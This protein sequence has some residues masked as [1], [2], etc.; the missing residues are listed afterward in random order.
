MLIRM[1]RTFCSSV[2]VAFAV[3]SAAV[4]GVS[5][6]AAVAAPP[7]ATAPAPA[8]AALVPAPAAAA[9]LPGL[10]SLPAGAAV[11]AGTALPAGPADGRNEVKR[12]KAALLTAGDLPAGYQR[13]GKPTIFK[14]NLLAVK[15][16]KPA[17]CDIALGLNTATAPAKPAEAPAPGTT[18]LV[19]L[20]KS[21]AEQVILEILSVGA[22]GAPRAFV[23][24]FA[25]QI[26]RCPK[27]TL[28]VDAST[29]KMVFTVSPL[30]MPSLGEASSAA[31]LTVKMSGL[32]A[33]VHLTMVAFAKGR[34]A[35]L[36]AAAGAQAD[37]EGFPA[38]AQAAVRRLRGLG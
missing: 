22:A 8:A 29:G 4:A 27:L 19:M 25:D 18:A 33:P 12:L 17:P 23:A 26:R 7:S 3:G 16:S 28:S 11:L 31:M 10:A 34:A 36:I 5:P 37:L 20:A 32:D 9:L 38:I 13:T 14:G 21:D 6:D 1:K 2:T 24:A 30:P 35:G 15:D